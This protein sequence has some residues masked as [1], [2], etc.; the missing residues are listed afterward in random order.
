M[1]TDA[2]ETN[3]YFSGPSRLIFL[4]VLEPLLKWVKKQPTGAICDWYMPNQNWYANGEDIFVKLGSL[5]RE[6]MTA[7]HRGPHS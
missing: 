6:P 7:W 5:V 1:A 2:N 4:G 3:I